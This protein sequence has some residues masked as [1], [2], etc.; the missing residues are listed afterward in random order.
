MHLDEKVLV[1]FSYLI[2]LRF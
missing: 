2:H 1:K